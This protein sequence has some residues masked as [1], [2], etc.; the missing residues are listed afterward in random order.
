MTTTGL[1]F[2]PLT[3][4]TGYFVGATNIGVITM[5]AEDQTLL[6]LVDTPNTLVLTKY[7][8]ERQTTQL[9]SACTTIQ[10]MISGNT[11]HDYIDHYLFFFRAGFSNHDC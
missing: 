4:H 2:V 5:P 6:W 10:E 3:S 7:L 1:D 9:D 8:W 11:V